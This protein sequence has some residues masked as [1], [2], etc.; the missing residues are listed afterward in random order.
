MNPLFNYFI[1]KPSNIEL[2]LILKLFSLYT[3]VTCKVLMCILV[4]CFVFV[5]RQGSHSFSKFKNR[6]FQQTFLKL[7]IF[8]DLEISNVNKFN[9]LMAL[10]L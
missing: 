3:H 8:K 5:R 2:N 6:T 1:L 9:I 4:Y 7:C 10:F